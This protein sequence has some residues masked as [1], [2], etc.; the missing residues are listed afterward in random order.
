VEKAQKK[1]ADL[2][3]A[4]TAEGERLARLDDE[5]LQRWVERELCRIV[6]VSES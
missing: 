2:I 1:R 4:A 5:S 6:P 3:A